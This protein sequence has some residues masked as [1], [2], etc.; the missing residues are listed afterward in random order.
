[1]IS[2]RCWMVGWDGCEACE[3][4]HAQ[5]VRLPPAAS[6]SRGG[7]RNT[8]SERMAPQRDHGINGEGPSGLRSSRA[9]TPVKREDGLCCRNGHR[10]PGHL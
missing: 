6:K 2:E 3:G 9:G 1:L 8:V 5:T 4:H 10:Y 7:V